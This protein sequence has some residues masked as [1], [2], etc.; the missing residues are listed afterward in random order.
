MSSNPEVGNVFKIVAMLVKAGARVVEHVPEWKDSQ[1]WTEI[2]VGNDSEATLACFHARQDAED[3][4]QD[5]QK[6]YCQE[7]LRQFAK[8]WNSY[9]VQTNIY[10][11][12]AGSSLSSNIGGGRW[13]QTPRG[14]S[15]EDCVR[16]GCQWAS[17]PLVTFSFAGSRYLPAEAIEAI[18]A[19]C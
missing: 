10:G 8:G 11:F 18:R 19:G 7:Q 5:P 3:H 16:Q 9:N 15:L 4:G 17:K 12:A 13:S 14:W 1:P 2:V 6:A